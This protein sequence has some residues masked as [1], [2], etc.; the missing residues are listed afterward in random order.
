MTNYSPYTVGNGSDSKWYV[1]GPGNGTGYY[2]GTLFSDM[3][4]SNEEDVKAATKVAN[5]AYKA[6][7]KQ[8]QYDI[9]KS[10]GIT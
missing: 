10:L 2:S 5:E 3:R 9:R 1:D 6:G 4:I 8:A 7:Y